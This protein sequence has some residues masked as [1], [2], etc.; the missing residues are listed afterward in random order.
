MK[1]RLPLLL[2]AAVLASFASAP[3]YASFPLDSPYDLTG[4]KIEGQIS[5]ELYDGVDYTY[6]RNEENAPFISGA[7]GRDTLLFTSAAGANN[8]TLSFASGNT[9]AFYEINS[10]TFENLKRL[11]F[12]SM[13][14][15]AIYSEKTT[16]IGTSLT[17]S[18][19]MD[20]NAGTNDVYF[21]NNSVTGNCGGAIHAI[22]TTVGIDDNGGVLFDG[23]KAKAGEASSGNQGTTSGGVGGGVAQGYTLSLFGVQLSFEFGFNFGFK[24]EYDDPETS[25]VEGMD[26]CGGAVNIVD[27]TLTMNANEGVT[28]TNNSAGDYGGAISASPDSTVQIS[29][30]GQVLF[31]DN[32]TTGHVQ[33]GHVVGGAGGAIFVGQRGQL[34]MDSN[35]DDIIFK[36]NQAAAAGGAIYFGGQSFTDDIVSIALTNTAG[37]I[38]FDGNTTGGTGGAIYLLQGGRLAIAGNKGDV[39]FERNHAGVSGGA[40]SAMDAFVTI[41]HNQQVVFSDNLI[42]RQDVNPE[43]I[44]S[45]T[46]YYVGGAI[47]GTNIQIHNN[48]SVLFERNAER[49]ANDYF[50][51][52]SLY[53]EGSA[54]HSE[55]SLSAG[56]GQT[57]EFRDS[58]YIAAGIQLHL[59]SGY[60]NLK[61]EGDIIFTG[62]TTVKDLETVKK[63]WVD[64][65]WTSGDVP[66][67]ASDA[68]IEDSRTSIVLGTTILNGGRLRV[69]KGAIFKSYNIHLNEGSNSTLRIDDAK[70]VNIFSNGDVGSNSYIRVYKGSTLEILGNSTIEGGKLIFD[71]GANWSFGL[72]DKNLLNNAALAFSGNSVSINGKLTVTVDVKDSNMNEHYCL[73]QGSKDVYKNIKNQWT[74]GN[75][76]VNGLNDA[77]GASFDDLVWL[78]NGLYYISTMVWGNNLGTWMWNQEDE[79]WQNGKKFAHGMNVKFTD[80][81]A[82]EVKLAGMLA[83]GIVTVV[84][85]EGHD[86]T[87]AAADAEGKLAGG[88][89]LIK[90]G[91]GALTLNLANEYSGTTHLEEGTLNLHNSKALG[92][93]TLKA[94]VGTKLGVGNNAHVVLDKAADSVASTV[95]VDANATLEIKGEAGSNY[96]APNTTINGTLAFTDAGTVAI[97]TLTGNEG[98]KLQVVN[99]CVESTGF[100]STAIHRN[101][102]SAISVIGGGA[103]LASDSTIV[104]HN[105]ID[106]RGGKLNIKNEGELIVDYGGKLNMA[107]GASADEVATVT[108]ETVDICKD[109][110][111][112]VSKQDAAVALT[113]D[114]ASIPDLADVTILNTAVGGEFHTNNL[115]L[116]WGSTLVL[117]KAHIDL[118]NGS[119]TL[120]EWGAEKIQLVLTLDGALTENNAVVLFSH[121]DSLSMGPYGHMTEYTGAFYAQDYFTGSMIGENSMIVYDNGT[122]FITGLVPEPTTATLSLLALAGLAARRRRR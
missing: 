41:E 40:I 103:S 52:R 32:I 86:Y 11:K 42:F 28:F 12:S 44:D 78:D 81:A 60:A 61:Q 113:L 82:G 56:A 84:N 100:T 29:H 37:D 5:Y 97:G 20:N 110:A 1:L 108:A 98:G 34:V 23:N 25:E 24:Y 55:V 104:T 119:L 14:S 65:N 63:D 92:D 16:G 105:L 10:L 59:N 75:I 57:I 33:K 4:G 76:T 3:V 38:S 67:T 26:I 2:A 88:M 54:E 46:S 114:Y 71:D 48:E 13:S 73:Y 94:A 111:L 109:A 64:N 74:A 95:T 90:R 117:D 116:E 15:G 43:D 18:G 70:V 68:E 58:I 62:A 53:V 101:F 45:F 7:T 31:Q 27:S 35:K 118:N 21:S 6:Q 99:S 85:S 112:F 51:L 87:F 8:V 93:S 91:T 69:E 22:S 49:V 102:M 77:A 47:Y 83:P 30:N 107:S 122:V 79:N 50:R 106:L 19:I 120:K 36:A 9:Q 121:V 89:D 96:Q 80:T 39:R 66:L 17:I 115:T 72:S